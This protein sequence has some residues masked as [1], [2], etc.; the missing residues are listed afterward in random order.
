MS[1]EANKSLRIRRIRETSVSL[2]PLVGT[3]FDIL[4]QTFTV[5]PRLTTVNVTHVDEVFVGSIFRAAVAADHEHVV[6]D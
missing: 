6:F 3:N 5:E 1:P 4:R 2:P